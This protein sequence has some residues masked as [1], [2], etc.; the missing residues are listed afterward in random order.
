MFKIGQ[1]ILKLHKYLQSRTNVK[2][3]FKFGLRIQHIIELDDLVE[4][5]RCHVRA[6]SIWPCCLGME[7]LRKILLSTKEEMKKKKLPFISPTQALCW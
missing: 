1:S 6:G 2:P 5:V 3:S 4:A 7:Q